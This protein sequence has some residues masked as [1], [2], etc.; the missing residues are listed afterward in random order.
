MPFT[1]HNSNS[2]CRDAATLEIYFLGIVD[3]ESALVL[4]NRLVYEISGRNDRQGTLLLCEHP[5]LITVGREGSREDILVEPRDLT[6]LQLP[7][8]WLNRGGGCLVHA[9]G[10]LAVY[11]V[12]PLDRLGL[13]LAEY[14][15]HLQETLIDVCRETNVSA[16]CR[17]GQSGV[18]S[19][20]GQ[21]AHV[22]VAVKSWVSYHGFFLNVSPALQLQRLV[23]SNA[24]D[25][26]V[27]S[28]SAE[29]VRR[30]PMHLVRESIVRKLTERLGYER[31][32]V[33]TGHPLFRRTRKTALIHA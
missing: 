31:W 7:V 33:Y 2:S 30:T 18:F 8:R 29:R 32:H 11:P 24:D 16:T 3:F 25:G 26:S 13:G 10:Q 14:R 19:R 27:T 9:P 6:A 1:I 12:L 28:L 4:Q 5:P 20:G 17:P 15:R 23:R 22:G 21:L